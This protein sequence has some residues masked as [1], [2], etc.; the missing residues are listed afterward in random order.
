MKKIRALFVNTSSSGVSFWRMFNFWPAAVRTGVM[1][2]AMPFWQKD[3]SESHPWQTD[4][5]NVELKHAYLGKLGACLREA[6]VCV[7]QMAHF[8]DALNVFLS[9]RDAYEE[10]RVPMVAECDDN[11][12]NTPAY[13]PASVS[14]SPGTE[15]RDVATKQFKL[16]DAMVVSTPG[17][18]DIYSDYN[19]HIY[20][21]PNSIDF[22]VW[23]T[24]K[25]RKKRKPGILIGWAGGANH[26]H[27]LRVM[28]PVVKRILA[29]YRDVRFVFVHGVPNYLKGIPG[30]EVVQKFVPINHYPS[31]LA[32]QDFN[33][34]IAPLEDNAFN[35]CKSNLRWLEY[36]SLGIPTVASRVGH[37]A[38]TINHG[39]DGFL[40]D[41][42]SKPK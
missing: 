4:M 24:A 26:D 9:M 37:F 34:G 14:Y 13:N 10:V 42:S 36:S 5:R 17:L 29:K 22:A 35:A 23:G 11:Y 2:I 25:S 32:S 28:E 21:V 39:V 27:D 1:D 16:A 38:Q 12:R 18:K 8:R 19:E 15:H 6:D 40:V 31:F 41:T 30:V 33:I 7:F 3:C 20:V